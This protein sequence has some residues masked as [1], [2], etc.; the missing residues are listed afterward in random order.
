M[1]RY[2]SHRNRVSTLIHGRNRKTKG[3]RRHREN[4]LSKRLCCRRAGLDVELIEI[5]SMAALT[6]PLTAGSTF[7]ALRLDP[8]YLQSI[9]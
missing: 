4:K 8:D 1:K 7:F 3:A 9:T 2:T 5:G 6:W